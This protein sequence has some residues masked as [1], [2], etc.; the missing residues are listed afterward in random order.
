MNRLASRLARTGAL[1]LLA[2]PF[3]AAADQGPDVAFK[4][5]TGFNVTTPDDHLQTSALGF[6][7]NLGWKLGPGTLNTEVGYFYKPGRQ[8]RESVSFPSD[9]VARVPPN[10][11]PA[12][13]VDSRKNSITQVNL[14]LSWEAAINETW[15]WQAGLM[16]GST[17]YR[18][19]YLGDVS[20][21]QDTAHGDPIPSF[22]DTYNGTPTKS[23]FTVS[24]FVGVTYKVSDASS[25]ELNLISVSYKSVNFVHTPGS[26]IVSGDPNHAGDH[27]VYAGDHLD[28]STRNSVHIEIGYAFHF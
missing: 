26:P 2:A 6:G 19:E 25:L 14:R 1:L 18:Q 22:E 13:S 16:V 27:L 12:P 23:Q 21:N 3:L 7:L 24:P 15:N 20:H 4:V 5:R 10:P 11:N 8:Y 17:K 9:D 28:T